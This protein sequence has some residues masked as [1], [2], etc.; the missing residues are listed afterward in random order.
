MGDSPAS[1][2]GEPARPRAWWTGA[3]RGSTDGAGF[4]K[5]APGST[6]D[7][8]HLA[9]NPGSMNTSHPFAVA[10]DS[11][12]SGPARDA[13]GIP[14]WPRVGAIRSPASA[15]R[16]ALSGLALLLAAPL[17]APADASAPAL[18]QGHWV[19]RQVA[20]DRNDTIRRS[21]EPDDPRLMGAVLDIQADGTIAPSREDCTRAAWRAHGTA[22]RAVRRARAR[23]RGLPDRAHERPDPGA[24]A[25]LSAESR[26]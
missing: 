24:D 6:H 22:T 16:A 5:R 3:R 18:L 21:A 4:D 20:V 13:T 26:P 12:A 8:R 15:A 25:A 7:V 2:H 11:P 14:R 1:A 23:R 10:R 17:A 9:D 19:V